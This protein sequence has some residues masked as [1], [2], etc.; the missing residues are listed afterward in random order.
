MTLAATDFLESV[1]Y[2]QLTWSLYFNELTPVSLKLE[3]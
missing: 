3:S 1:F 2:T